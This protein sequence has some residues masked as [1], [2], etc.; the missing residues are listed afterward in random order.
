MHIHPGHQ[1]VPDTLFLGVETSLA[2]QREL[3][4]RERERGREGDNGTRRDEK[5]KWRDLRSAV[6]TL[7]ET[8]NQT[9]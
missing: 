9:K 3:T 8:E 7:S 2:G 1:I 6:L 4:P 5:D